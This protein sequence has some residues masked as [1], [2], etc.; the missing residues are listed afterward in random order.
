M[1]LCLCPRTNTEGND[2][3]PLASVHARVSNITRGGSTNDGPVS[4]LRRNRILYER[5]SSVRLRSRGGRTGENSRVRLNPRRGPPRPSRLRI[6]SIPSTEDGVC[7][8]PEGK[9]R[10]S[11]TVLHR[12]HPS[13]A[14]S[15]SSWL[16][17]DQASPRCGD[18]VKIKEEGL[19]GQLPHL[20]HPCSLLAGANRRCTAPEERGT[21]TG[22]DTF[23]LLP[24]SNP[25]LCRGSDRI[26]EAPSDSKV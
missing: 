4:K 17:A 8:P 5:R 9:R 7:S 23:E 21:R 10:G 6:F 26:S 19:F 18:A 3:D 15:S 12:M 20:S 16:L 2:R 11:S 22:P 1:G 25:M 13:L 24:S 14:S